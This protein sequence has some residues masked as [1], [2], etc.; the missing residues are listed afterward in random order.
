MEQLIASIM[1]T[2]CVHLQIMILT[3][4]RTDPTGRQK[5][6]HHYHDARDGSPRIKK[7][8]ESHVKEISTSWG[9]DYI[10]NL[11]R[12]K[13][14]VPRLKDPEIQGNDMRTRRNTNVG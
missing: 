2:S 4:S 14:K 5:L 1:I 12:Q 10:I 11:V 6:V 13:K 8:L 7:S 9:K 3:Y